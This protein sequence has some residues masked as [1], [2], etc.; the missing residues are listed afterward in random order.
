MHISPKERAEIEGAMSDAMGGFIER[1]G[2]L[3]FSTWTEEE[4][5]TFI[6]VAFDLSVP[7]VFMK[8]IHVSGPYY[9]DKVPF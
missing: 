2:K 7:T 8:R 6:G 1:L 9:H 4:W 3:D 5:K